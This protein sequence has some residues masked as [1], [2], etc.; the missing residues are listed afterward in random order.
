MSP[1]APR[2]RPRLQPYPHA[3]TVLVITPVSSTGHRNRAAGEVTL[4]VQGHQLCTSYGNTWPP[5]ALCR[6]WTVG[7]GGMA[8]SRHFLQKGG[9]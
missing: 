6:L 3:Y 2:A 8:E 7:G 5:K 1:T 9:G 4:R